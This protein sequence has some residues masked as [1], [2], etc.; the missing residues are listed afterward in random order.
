MENKVSRDGS[1]M[2][3]RSLACRESGVYPLPPICW[4]HGVGGKMAIDLWGSISC[5]QN[6]DVKELR[7]RFV[8]ARWLLP[9]VTAST[10]I[11]D[12]N[13][14]DKVRYHRE[15][16]EMVQGGCAFARTPYF[17]HRTR[18]DGPPRVPCV[19]G[20]LKKNR[21]QVRASGFVVKPHCHQR[22]RLNNAEPTLKA[23]AEQLRVPRWD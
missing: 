9:T 10:M 12:L 16:V 19:P 21:G 2:A 5:G 15:L 22:H 7:R 3:D 1:R 8:G 11:A 4:N 17:S 20:F 18:N 14:A 13:L 6:P 23:P